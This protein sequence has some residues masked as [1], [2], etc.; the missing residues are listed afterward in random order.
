MN[1]RGL[2]TLAPSRISGVNAG[3]TLDVLAPMARGNRHDWHSTQ[4]TASAPGWRAIC[5]EKSKMLFSS[6]RAGRQQER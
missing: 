5:Y 1:A 4:P 3:L 6:R 2:S